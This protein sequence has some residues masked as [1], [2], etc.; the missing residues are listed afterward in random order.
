MPG[1]LPGYKVEVAEKTKADRSV[2]CFSANAS[3]LLALLLFPPFCAS[4]FCRSDS[5]SLAKKMDLPPSPPFLL[6]CWPLEDVGL[7]SGWITVIERRQGCHGGM[8]M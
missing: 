7:D 4:L 1:F 2:C 3:G 6:V 8:E 5:V